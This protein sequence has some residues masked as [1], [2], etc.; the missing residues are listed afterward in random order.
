MARE[1]TFRPVSRTDYPLLRRWLAQEHVRAFWGPPA[2][3]VALID[4][5]IDGGD[6][7]MFVVHLAGRPVG[8][9]QDWCPHAEGA[10]H[11]ADMPPGTRAIDCVLGATDLLG[12]GIARRF[13]R[14]RAGALAAAGTPAIVTDPHAGNAR[15]IAMYRAA[16]FAPLAER[17]D[18]EG[19]PVLCMIHSSSSWP[20]YSGGAGGQCPPL[21]H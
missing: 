8:Y 2:R 12:H 9:I 15:A 17:R 11:L 4:A 18:H 10:P 21:R 13:V 5:D 20:K 1:I 6:T 16:G 19:A 3:E 7:A 14:A